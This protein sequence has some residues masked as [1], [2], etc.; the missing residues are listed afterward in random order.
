MTQLNNVRKIL[1]QDYADEYRTL[2]SKLSEILNS[3]MV[4]TTSVVNG[5][6]DFTNLRQQYKV[7]KVTADGS[8]NVTAGNQVKL[9]IVGRVIGTTCINA[10]NLTDGAVYPTGT[11]FISWTV[12]NGI[13]KINNI[14]NL[15]ASNEY[16]ISII[17]RYDNR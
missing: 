12:N 3:F 2:I 15:Q 14:S 5:N 6:I 4:D 17:I 11:P 16:E 7:F 13:L 10:R 9:G 8:G 1:A